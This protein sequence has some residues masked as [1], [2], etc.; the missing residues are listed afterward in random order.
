MRIESI[1][2]E[3]HYLCM[4][5]SIDSGKALKLIPKERRFRTK[6]KH[7]KTNT[8]RNEKLLTEEAG[9]T[10]TNPEKVKKMRLDLKQRSAEKKQREC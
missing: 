1:K 10:V 2:G 5:S 8:Q 3:W 4:L 6:S 9:W 7:T